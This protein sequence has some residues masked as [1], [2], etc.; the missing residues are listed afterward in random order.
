MLNEEI[1]PT[2]IGKKY[3]K[4]PTATSKQ[5]RTFGLFLCADCGVT[6]EKQISKKNSCFCP[7]CSL[8]HR[9]KRKEV[10]GNCESNT[11]LYNIHRKIKSRCNSKT[12]D[13]Y[14]YYGARGINICKEWNNFSVFKKWALNNGYK[15]NLTIDREDNNGNYEPSNCR[16]VDRTIQSRN[17]RKLRKNN[18]SGY[19]G[20]S[21]HPSG[22]IVQ[23]TVSNKNIYLG[24]TNT[25]K[26]GAIMYDRY[27]VLNN[28]EHTTN[29]P[30]AIEEVRKYA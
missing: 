5:K 26:E 16:W 20:V 6:H 21:K 29:F 14:E 3:R 4:F 28:L 12:N 15:D 25:A 23:I 27:I 24:V 2:M 10:L 1:T 17:T 30:K 22:W 7:V 13:K 9:P 19:R 18:T 8:L 11:R